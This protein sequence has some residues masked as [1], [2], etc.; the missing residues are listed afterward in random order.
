MFLMQMFIND[1]DLEIRDIIKNGPT[2]HIINKEG[3]KILKLEN[4]YSESDLELEAKNYKLIDLLYGSLNSDEFKR[5][6]SFIGAK[7]MFY[8]FILTYSGTSQVKKTII[9]FIYPYI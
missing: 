3:V 7:D 9:S 4:N 6:S 2:T 8:K 1:H 5:I